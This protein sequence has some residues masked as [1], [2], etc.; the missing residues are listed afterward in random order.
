MVWLKLVLCC[1]I[2]L[3]AGTK[4]ARYGDAISERTGLGRMWIGLIL[5]GLVTSMPEMVTGVSAAAIVGQPDLALG[6][7]WGSCI[8]NLSILAFL[9][10]F[11]RK[12]PL[13]SAASSRYIL[14]AFLGIALI[15]VA[16]ISLLIGD[17]VTGI[18][19][20]WLGLTSIF[21][22]TLYIFGIRQ[23]FIYN[24]NHPEA[25]VEEESQYNELSNL[26]IYGTFAIAALGIIGGGIWLSFIGDEIAVTYNLSANFVGSLF[27]AIATSLPEIVVAITALRIGAID[28]AVGDIL[29][30]NMLNTANIF[31]TDIFYTGGPLLSEVSSKNLFTALAMIVMTLIVIL[32]L[33]FKNK[34]KTFKIISWNALLI[35]AIYI[36]TSLYLFNN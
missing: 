19:I 7:F 25:I 30:A 20:G 1:L 17:G 3:F 27:L 21:I 26:K 22:F 23:M 28:L 8:F 13:L 9:D 14:P 16:G 11:H 36:S 35:L 31:I 10:M 29:G 2:I 12:G 4:L 15:S 6:N 18:S 5:I 34:R 24:K 33:R 32:G